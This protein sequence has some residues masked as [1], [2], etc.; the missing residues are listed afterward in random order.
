MNQPI[1]KRLPKKFIPAVF[2]LFF[3]LTWVSGYS[4][5]TDVRI[6]FGVGYPFNLGN[7]TK[8][9]LTDSLITNKRLSLN[10]YGGI[11]IILLNKWTFDFNSSTNDYNY[12]SDDVSCSVSQ[13]IGSFSIG[14]NWQI[15]EK[16]SFKNR[17]FVG[18]SQLTQSLSVTNEQPDIWSSYKNND[19]NYYY[20]SSKT[21][22]I[23][24]HHTS[25]CFKMGKLSF[26][27][28]NLAYSF[29]RDRT[30]Q[31]INNQPAFKN[32]FTPS[33]GL[34]FSLKQDWFKK[35]TEYPSP[36]KLKPLPE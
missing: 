11:E 6:S 29:N 19:Q 5:K 32:V 30:K 22:F 35:D 4:Q 16:I 24:G 26:F 17:L 31:L 7:E 8:Q 23:I 20:N 12:R 27:T 14:Y 34:I 33:I 3:S 15:T 18:G 36:D 10:Y 13:Y 21:A 25:F 28:V 1:R 9:L 2:L